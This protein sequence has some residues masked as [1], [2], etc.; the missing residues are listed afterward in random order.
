MGGQKINKIKKEKKKKKK[1]KKLY[2]R[3]SILR[4]AYNYVSKAFLL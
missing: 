1:K 3:T 2:L 4:K